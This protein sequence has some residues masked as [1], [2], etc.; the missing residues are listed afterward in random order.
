[1]ASFATIEALKRVFG[2]RGWYQRRQAAKWLNARASVVDDYGAEAFEELLD[3]L[4]VYRRQPRVPPDGE[5]S[6]PQGAPQHVNF[7]GDRDRVFNLPTEQLAGQVGAAADIAMTPPDRGRYS[8]LLSSLIGAPPSTS[9]LSAASA[10]AASNED[11]AI[12]YAQRIR[13]GVD[14]MQISISERWRRYL[15][16]GA[17]WISGLYGIGL[18]HAADLPAKSEPRYVLA[19]LLLGGLFSWVAR[20]LAA[21]IERARR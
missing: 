3:A 1:L 8:K 17:M 9:W 13:A 14:Q 18:T 20:D 5:T 11:E 16:G 12:E 21:V 15:Q 7:P 6:A 10:D 19:S 4:G 2:L